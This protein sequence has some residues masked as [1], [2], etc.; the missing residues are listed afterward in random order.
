MPPE[1]DATKTE[2]TA[3]AAAPEPTPD[4]RIASLT[5]ERDAATARIAE[6]EAAATDAAPI[7]EIGR[8]A[9]RE[10]A[11]QAILG[12]AEIIDGAGEAFAVLL[13]TTAAQLGINLDKPLADEDR[14]RLVAKAFPIAKP[15]LVASKPGA[16]AGGNTEPFNPKPQRGIL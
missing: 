1:A 2:A 11:R 13:D 4:E 9:N 5:G 6:L 12:G 10:T 16:S 8:K 14:R 3:S 7:L 15:L